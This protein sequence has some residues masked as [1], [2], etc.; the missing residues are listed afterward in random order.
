[1]T[2]M[3]QKPFMWRFLFFSVLLV[4]LILSSQ[5]YGA[6]RPDS[7]KK[8]SESDFEYTIGLGDVLEVIVWKEEDISKQVAVRLDGRISLPLLGDVDAVGKTLTELAAD[9]KA[10]LSELIAEP[11]V[12][13]MLAQ[14]RSWR[15]YVIG[16]IKQPGEFSIDYPITVIQALAKSGGFLE[17]A[18]KDEIK[19]VRKVSGKD[20]LLDFDYDDF[21][22]GKDIKQNV[23]VMPEDVIVVP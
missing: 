15:Y 6:E 20:T 10:K 1:M 23:V 22:K 21:V 17:W 16:Q 7:T 3:T 4:S 19:I 8:S 13:V 11:S 5:V 12:S 2:H 9:L 18:K 14:S